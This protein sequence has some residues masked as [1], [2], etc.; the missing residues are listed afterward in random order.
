MRR[1]GATMSETAIHSSKAQRWLH[2]YC[3]L[4]AGVT[5]AL[6]LFGTTDDTHEVTH[7]PEPATLSAA[8]LAAVRAASKRTRALVLIPPVG[9]SSE[10]EKQRFFVSTASR[11]TS[12]AGG[13]AEA[14][15]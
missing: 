8:L 7:W 9:D 5:P 15:S 10:A 12:C 6:V 1:T 2:G 11:W 4:Q 14:Q 3:E 13:G